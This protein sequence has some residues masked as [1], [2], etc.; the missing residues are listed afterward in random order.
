MDKIT[1]D[2]TRTIIADFASEI[3]RKA[4]DGPKPST[5][6]IHFRSEDRNNIERPVKYVP[7][8]LLRFRKNNGRIASDVYSYEKDKGPLK[9]DSAEAQKILFDFL[10]KKDPEKTQDLINNISQ[11]KQK[12]AAII[13]ADGFLINGNRRK[14]ALQKL[15]DE[16]SDSQYGLMKVVIL[17]GENDPGGP[18]TLKEI[19]QIENRYQL[20]SEGKSEYYGFDRALSIRRK[21]RLGM[22]LK[23]QLKDDPN[24]Y[25][26]TDKEF[27][28]VVKDYEEQ[29]LK[30]LECIDRYLNQ[31]DRPD[32]YDTISV[33]KEGRWQA[34]L[35]YY[36]SVQKKLEDEMWRTKHNIEEDQVGDIEEIAFKI[37]RK[38][39]FPGVEKV[40]KIMRDLPKLI[41]NEE[42]KKKIYKILEV[43]PNLPKEEC[44][45]N[46]K[47]I[48][49]KTK[50]IKWSAKN[51]SKIVGQVKQAI[52]ICDYEKQRETP[53]TLLQTALSKLQHE[54]MDPN[55]I[56]Y[57]DNGKAVKLAE[58]IRDTADELKT[59]FW[60]NLKNFQKLKGESKLTL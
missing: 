40:H 36:K 47:E 6:V 18:P 14:V 49:E 55:A 42:A 3:K 39:D 8:T 15:Y 48:D 29:F 41:V 44:Y 52:Q 1:Q 60:K 46:G 23:E 19:E 4:T 25:K 35:D 20:Q 11:Y 27:N 12:E 30:P 32:R 7:I 21:M 50:D 54:S 17:P 2:T 51:E 58:E 9:E 59:E 45:E 24:Y 22:S 13:T 37:I 38:K 34:F 53:I 43:E 10:Y 28:K 33:G 26:L 5:Q 57:E 56:N 16:T 31:L